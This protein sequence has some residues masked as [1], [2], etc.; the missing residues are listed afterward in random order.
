MT[1][2]FGQ[3]LWCLSLIPAMDFKFCNVIMWANQGYLDPLNLYVCA[4]YKTEHDACLFRTNSTIWKGYKNN[5]IILKEEK[6]ST[7]A[8]L[9]STERRMLSNLFSLSAGCEHKMAYIKVIYSW[10]FVRIIT[11]SRPCSNAVFRMAANVNVFVQSRTSAIF[12]VSFN[13]WEQYARRDWT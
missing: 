11:L 13:S 1:T 8:L 6:R 5:I 2:V 9:K 4:H 7:N 10:H 3:P 12:S